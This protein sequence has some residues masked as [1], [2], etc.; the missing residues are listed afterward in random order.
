[1]LGAWIKRHAILVLV[2]VT[3]GSPWGHRGHLFGLEH[4]E[5]LRMVAQDV[6]TDMDRGNA[7]ARGIPRLGERQYLF[8]D[9]PGDGL[10][11][12]GGGYPRRGGHNHRPAQG[13]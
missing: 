7:L 2:V 3:V 1:M 6:T 10:P 4:A 5:Y 13:Q 8:P 12:H 11:L 9:R